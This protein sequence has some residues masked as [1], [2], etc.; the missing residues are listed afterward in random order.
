M[1][2]I[3]WLSLG[4]TSN[5]N[6]CP[7][8]HSVLHSELHS[9]HLRAPGKARKLQRRHTC[10]VRQKLVTV[11]LYPL[12]HCFLQGGGRT[13]NPQCH[14]SCLIDSPTP[15]KIECGSNSLSLCFGLPDLLNLL[16]FSRSSATKLRTSFTWVLL[17]QVY[18]LLLS[19][20][21]IRIGH[22]LQP[23]TWVTTCCHWSS[24]WEAASVIVGEEF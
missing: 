12:S 23:D 20:T 15:G 3:G 5:L 17:S 14:A 10:C 1:Q 8:H 11:P 13:R 19:S 24:V 21:D 22:I 7:H 9:Y 6:Q 16:T 18:L 2:G 4:D